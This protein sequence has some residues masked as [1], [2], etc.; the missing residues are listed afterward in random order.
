M[1]IP[2]GSEKFIFGKIYFI[3]LSFEHYENK[4][5]CHSVNM[6]LSNVTKVQERQRS[7]YQSQISCGRRPPSGH[8]VHDTADVAKGKIVS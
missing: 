6:M 3:N 5:S 1:R 4:L 7:N 8:L 2:A